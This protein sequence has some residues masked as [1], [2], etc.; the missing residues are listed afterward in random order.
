MRGRILKCQPLELL[1]LLSGEFQVASTLDVDWQIDN[2][3]VAEWFKAP[4]L[5]TGV[6][7]TV[8]WVQIPPHPLI[9]LQEIHQ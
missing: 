9:S 7:A 4:V 5:K 1:R 3:W 8:P 6:R 2:G